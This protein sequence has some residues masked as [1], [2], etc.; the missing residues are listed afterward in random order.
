MSFYINLLSTN[1][2]VLKRSMQVLCEKQE[3]EVFQHLSKALPVMLQ[4]GVAEC[5]RIIG[6]KPFQSVLQSKSTPVPKLNYWTP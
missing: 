2:A 3:S 6:L 5:S 4:K 1:N